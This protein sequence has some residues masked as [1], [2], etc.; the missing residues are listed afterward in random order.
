[1]RGKGGS[2]G[3]NLRCL[4]LRDNLSYEEKNKVF[5]MGLLEK[6]LMKKS[7]IGALRVNFMRERF[8]RVHGDEM[9][10]EGR[11]NPEKIEP[12]RVSEQLF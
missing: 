3:L 2:V 8:L 7:F 11:R 10:E 4:A 5:I 12:Q 1:M 9:E 6:Q